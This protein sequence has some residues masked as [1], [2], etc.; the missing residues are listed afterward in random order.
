MSVTHI[1]SCLLCPS[2][3]PVKILAKEMPQVSPT[4]QAPES[5]AKYVQALVS[6]L[7]K[8]HPEAY[9]NA[10]A[11]SQTFF[12]VLILQNFATSD[13]G[14]LEGKNRTRALIHRLTRVN[15][16]ND[17]DLRM[18]LER[19]DGVSDRMGSLSEAALAELRD[20][21]DFLLEEGDYLAW[22]QPEEKADSIPVDA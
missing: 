3:K 9:R 13:P 12:G 19:L 8:K 17:M 16:V 7:E 21:R 5:V 20:L 4:E 2:E 22:E 1:T 14:V 15:D 18:R 6:H 10:L 11:I